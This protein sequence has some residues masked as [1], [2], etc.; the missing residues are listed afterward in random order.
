MQKQPSIF[1][2]ED[3]IEL[4]NIFAEILEMNGMTV[5]IIGDGAVA[6]QR[7]GADTP[8]LILLDM[9]LPNVSGVE[10][11]DY[12][13]SAPHLTNTKVV[14]V[15]ANPLLSADLEEKADLLLIKP[16]RYTQIS[17]LVT[18]LMTSK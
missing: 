13:R 7:L 10:I 4:A 1:V 16:V 11:L 3:A 5:E 12:V 14:A 15:T 18:R 6:M 17:E 2:I 9:H 8:D